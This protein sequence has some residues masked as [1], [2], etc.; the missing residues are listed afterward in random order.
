MNNTKCGSE[1]NN[2]APNDTF[3]QHAAVLLPEDSVL[4]VAVRPWRVR[5]RGK[6]I[7]VTV[8][9]GRREVLVQQ[10][11]RGGMIIVYENHG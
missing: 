2:V 4:G 11:L 1:L 3:R 7:R 5:I 8:E 9:L 6:R 10:S